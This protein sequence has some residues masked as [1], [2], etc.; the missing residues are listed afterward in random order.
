MV[1]QE[2]GR[3]GPARLMAPLTQAG[4]RLAVL[5]PASNPI[6]H[7]SHSHMQFDLPKIQSW[8][9]F[10]KILSDAFEQWRPRL[11]IAC[12]E[13]IVAMLH[14]VVRR[15]LAGKRIISDRLLRI[16]LESLGTPQY[17]DA[18]MLKS[19][20]R[21]LATTLGVPVPRGGCVSS[22]AEAIERANEI[23]YPVFVKKSFSW[24]GQGT[25]S[26][27]SDAEVKA[28]YISMNPHRSWA[29]ETVRAFLGRQ[30]YPTSSSTE[31]QH[32]CAGDSVMFNAVAWKG[33]YLGGF[34][35]AREQ[36]TKINGPST[37]VRLSGNSVCEDIARKL[38]AATGIT[39]FC[40]FDFIWDETKK[41]ATL[42]EC[43]PRPNQVGH[44]GDRIGV[45]LCTALAK[46]CK[47]EFPSIVSPQ[48]SAIIPLFP[49]E[50]MRD[51]E[52][53]VRLK[54]TLDIP[55]NDTKLLQFILN[56]NAKYSGSF[57]R[58]VNI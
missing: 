58:L 53:A 21:E 5:C 24:A 31:V 34:F 9:K 8:K 28:A 27:S 22:Q 23:G 42:L 26:C 2:A 11:I 3:W 30:W 55:K 40:A 17:F 10:V 51:E 47:G 35:G 7:S 25:I 1:A 29:R 39:G 43:N 20:T 38:V 44:L 18:M 41:T 37:I 50:W 45:D 14:F 19:D 12:D 57:Q 54:D 33:Q 52:N 6:G 56:S 16:L 4:F 46:A 13:Q 32:A 36:T 15:K 48:V 49:Q